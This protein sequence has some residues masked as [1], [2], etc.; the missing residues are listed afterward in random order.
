MR[1][2][3]IEG[4]IQHLARLLVRSLDELAIKLRIVGH[5][6]TGVTHFSG[7]IGTEVIDLPTLSL[8]RKGRV[9]GRRADYMHESH[10]MVAPVVAPKITGF[11]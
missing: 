1:T 4:V 2:T 6:Y 3:N 11:G 8:G 5:H 9:T 7:D 10:G